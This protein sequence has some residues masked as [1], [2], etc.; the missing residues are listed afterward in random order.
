MPYMQLIKDKDG[1]LQ[2]LSCS[3]GNVYPLLVDIPS[4]EHY[5]KLFLG[6]PNSQ[7][8]EYETGELVGCN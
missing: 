7:D 4:V 2:L 8:K 5:G 1:F 6:E 3:T